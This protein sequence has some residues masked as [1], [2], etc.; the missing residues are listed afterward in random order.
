VAGVIAALDGCIDLWFPAALDADSPRGLSAPA[1]LE[2][3]AMLPRTRIA[4]VSANVRA[5]L[6]AARAQ[7]AQDDRII[8]FGSFFVAAAALPG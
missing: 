3:M 8:V 6:A 5:A 1:L 4:P 2:R 7:A